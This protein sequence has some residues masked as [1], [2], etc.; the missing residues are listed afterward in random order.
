[1]CTYESV[2]CVLK[3]TVWFFSYW[4]FKFIRL[5]WPRRIFIS[6]VIHFREFVFNIVIYTDFF[7]SVVFKI[8]YILNAIFELRNFSGNLME[9]LFVNFVISRMSE[10]VK[11]KFCLEYQVFLPFHL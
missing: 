9:I 5:K 3:C 8:C 6:L 1:V 4:F 11:W 7:L 10:I 2:L